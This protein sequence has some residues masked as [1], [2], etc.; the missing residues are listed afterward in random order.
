MDT[1]DHPELVGKEF[2]VDVMGLDT[3]KVIYN[4]FEEPVEITY[5]KWQVSWE[6]LSGERLKKLKEDI[7]GDRFRFIY[8]IDG[9]P[10]QSGD[11]TIIGSYSSDESKNVASYDNEVDTTFS[12]DELV[13]QRVRLRHERFGI[14]EGIL[15]K[16]GEQYLVMK[17]NGDT[18]YFW[19]G[20][21]ELLED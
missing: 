5:N 10:Y 1:K 17:P 14:L 6:K 11:V 16:E 12:L 20:E 18:T 7:G 13:G 19:E 2:T 15:E 8:N 4:F 21:V 3:G 9:K